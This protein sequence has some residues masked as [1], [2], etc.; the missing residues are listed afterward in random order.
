MLIVVYL[1]NF[2]RVFCDPMN[3]SPLCSSA[4]WISQARILEWVAISCPGDLPDPEIKS[5]S[6]TLQA[7]SLPLSHLGTP[8]CIRWAPHPKTGVLLRRGNDTQTRHRASGM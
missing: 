5:R 2:V 8:C 7:G 4:H 3:C 6:P 1:L